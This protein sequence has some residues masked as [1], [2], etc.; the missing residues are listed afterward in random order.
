MYRY[1]MMSRKHN[2]L[3]GAHNTGKLA[4]RDGAFTLIEL[5][6]VIAIIAILAA[7][8][9][10]VFSRAQLASQ[11]TY[12]MNNLKELT[13][14]GIMFQHDN[15]SIAYDGTHGVW[16]TTL[17]D[18]YSKEDKLRLCPSAQ[19]PVQATG[20]G[21][22]PGTAANAWVWDAVIN[23]NPTN[24]GSY[25]VNGWL[26][27]TQGSSPPT[28]WVPDDP[29]GSYFQ[30]DTA[31]KYPSTTPEFL[32]AVWADLW[33][34]PTDAPD[35]PADLYDGGDNIPGGPMMQRALIAR[36]GSRPPGAAPKEAPVNSPFPGLL[37]MGLCDGHV[38]SIRLDKLW[39]CTWSETFT[40]TNRPGLP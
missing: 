7:L 34:Q 28:Q 2:G 15:G 39:A 23:P 10:P 19:Q 33:P 17:I 11:K 32:D 22:Q 8:V 26:Y 1:K 12:C 9:F 29:P 18:N 35:D 6:V 21:T 31:I 37:D 4:Y 3:R 36:H 38:E 16:L 30:N 13:T 5:L 14:A 40:P 24:M 27:N 20:A 25:A